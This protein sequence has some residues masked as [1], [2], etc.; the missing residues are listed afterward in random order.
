MRGPKPTM[1]NRAMGK[2]SEGDSVVSV[3]CR[4]ILCLELGHILWG[5]L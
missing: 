3:G 1:C 4:S 5:K 2:K